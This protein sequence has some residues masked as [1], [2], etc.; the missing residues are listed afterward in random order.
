MNIFFLIFG[1]LLGIVYAATMVAS[2]VWCVKITLARGIK[3]GLAACLG[4]SVAQVFWSGAAASAIFWLAWQSLN[5]DSLMRVLAGC[6]FI[7]MGKSVYQASR[8]T[9][10]RYEGELTEFY[11]VLKSTFNVAL[12]MRLRLPGYLALIVS[13]S[14]HLRQY[15]VINAALLAV[16]VG[17]GT[18]L[19]LLFF[20][21]LAGLFGKRV[22]EPITLHS[23]NKLRTLAVAVFAGLFLIVTAPMVFNFE[24]TESFMGGAER[25]TSSWIA[26]SS[27]FQGRWNHRLCCARYH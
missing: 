13:V 24:Y 3:A 1:I 6:T 22:P 19:W 8:L 11:T 7:Y 14:L 2:V 9:R 27:E 10:L 20:T 21:V 18:M 17:M 5:L 23:M 16:G 4:I 26:F 25:I 15:P 12:T